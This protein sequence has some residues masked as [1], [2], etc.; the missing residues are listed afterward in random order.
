MVGM[1]YQGNTRHYNDRILDT[2]AVLVKML[3]VG[4]T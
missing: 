4:T 2:L 1:I 3:Q